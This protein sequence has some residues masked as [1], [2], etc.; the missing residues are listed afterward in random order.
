MPADL[1][2]AYNLARLENLIEV[3]MS[4]KVKLSG[5]VKSLEQKREEVRQ[6]LFRTFMLQPGA[7][8]LF[9][10]KKHLQEKR[11]NLMKD[12]VALKESAPGG[13]AKI[14]EKERIQNEI[15]DVKEEFGTVHDRLN[16]Q[17]D[18]FVD[19]HDVWREEGRPLVRQLVDMLG[20]LEGAAGTA[21]PSG[22]T[23][24]QLNKLAAEISGLLEPYFNRGARENRNIDSGMSDRTVIE[25]R[26]INNNFTNA[27][28]D[29][30]RRKNYVLILDNL[31]ALNGAGDADR[32][33]GPEGWKARKAFVNWLSGQ[34]RTAPGRAPLLDAQGL[35]NF[36]KD[37]PSSNRDV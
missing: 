25:K 6:K 21:A 15:R 1:R 37:Y 7:S 23:T 3:S 20:Q 10:R 19:G 36:K 18:D 2:P 33:P 22:V 11:N 32:T 14:N 26:I 13:N 35:A 29:V 24:D 9:A 4:G 28:D 31:A 12:F 27:G 17:F 5:I 34:C 16:G 8:E 30:E